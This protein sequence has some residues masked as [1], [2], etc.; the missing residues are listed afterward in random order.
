MKQ[1]L[2]KIF[3]LS[4]Q[5][6]TDVIVGTLTHL[7]TD[8]LVLVT[9]VLIVL[10]LDDTLIA[11]LEG[12]PVVFDYVQYT[13]LS[14]S[15]VLLMILF[16]WLDYNALYM[17]CYNE[18]A[19]M[20]LTLAE[21]LRRLPLSFF[22]KKDVSNITTTMM[23]DVMMMEQAMSHFIPQLISSMIIAILFS[24]AMFWYDWRMALAVVWVVPVSFAITILGKRRQRVV[25]LRAQNDGL[26][27]A[28]K[29]Q[30]FVD[31]I[32][33]IK[34]NS[35]QEGHYAILRGLYDKHEH[36]LMM[37][38]LGT[39]LFVVNSMMVLKLGIVSTLVVG[40]HLL[41]QGEITL[42]AFLLYLIAT[43]LYDPLTNS[44]INLAAIFISFLSVK[45]MDE[46]T[47]KPIQEG[48]TAFTPKNF[49]LAFDKVV[50][51]YE[52]GKR[53]L[54]E[55]SFVARQGKVTALVG[56][57]GG[58]KSTALKLAARFWDIQSGQITLGGSNIAKIDPETLLRH[59][60]IVF[61]DV[62]LFNNTILE[63]IRIGRKGAT[64]DEV[65]AV[66]KAANCHEFIMSLPNGY[67]TVVGENGARLSGGQR[68]RLSIARALLKDAPV[69]LLDE[70]T[71]ALDV[72]SENE[73][74]EALARLTKD[75]T[76]IVVAHRMRTIMGA[77]QIILLAEG[78]VAEQGTHDELIAQPQSKY[79]RMVELQHLSN[80]WKINQ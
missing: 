76:V 14:V 38:E 6:A 4:D 29:V 45:R 66:A 56:P 16:Y 70:A 62:T 37:G 67:E 30:E 44:L 33:D 13:I 71:S 80:N 35:R 73:L 65:I 48:V 59:F 54:N 18:S 3:G 53:V 9:T 25:G 77:D 74:Q 17:R 51:E 31:N 26:A 32:K 46:I 75:K 2:K 24:G 79:A 50:F 69:I 15:L 10:F 12:S 64:D 11:T 21:R 49:D 63:N 41:S 27:S 8:L 5:G 7:V 19:T 22:G 68:Q 47:K 28:N 39:G 72:Q 61:Q 58:G 52:E 40:L 23:N 20:R 1:Q 57:S 43:R 36:S 60:S 42:M 55:A 78:E 34:A